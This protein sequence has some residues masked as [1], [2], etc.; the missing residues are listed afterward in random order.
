VFAGDASA[1]ADRHR[2]LLAEADATARE[3]RRER[4]Q[5]LADTE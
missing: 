1:E 5:R 2:D 3:D 4:L